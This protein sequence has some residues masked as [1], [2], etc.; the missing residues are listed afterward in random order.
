V[1]STAAPPGPIRAPPPRALSIDAATSMVTFRGPLAACQ[2]AAAA[3]EAQLVPPRNDGRPVV[4]A[5]RF[6]SGF[7]ES[8]LFGG[9]FD[10]GAKASASER[11]LPHRQCFSFN[12]ENPG[13]SA[14][15]R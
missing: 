9:A 3:L 2:T 15:R 13:R 10:S 4:K 11:F 8:V 7:V 5:L 1:N 12:I 6:P 14:I